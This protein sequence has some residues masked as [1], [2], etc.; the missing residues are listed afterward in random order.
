MS[1]KSVEY[2]QIKKT[3]KMATGTLFKKVILETIRQ[4]NIESAMDQI[5]LTKDDYRLSS[6][7]EDRTVFR[8]ELMRKSISVNQIRNSIKS[9]STWAPEFK[10]TGAF[11]EMDFKKEYHYLEG[12][13]NQ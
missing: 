2:G 6:V 7:K 3:L 13:E 12:L 11:I 10:E 8:I 5:N 9:R 4:K 1:I